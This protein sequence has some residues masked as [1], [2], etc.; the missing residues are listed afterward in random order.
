MA[1]GR[2]GHT[3]RPRIRYSSLPVV[4]VLATPCCPLPVYRA[5]NVVRSNHSS[6]CVACAGLMLRWLCLTSGVV[7][8]SLPCSS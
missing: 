8:R 1:D 3:Y 7:M 4:C 5:S 6:T 2:G